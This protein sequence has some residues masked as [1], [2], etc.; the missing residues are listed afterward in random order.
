MDMEF[1]KVAQE[2]AEVEKEIRKQ[3][4]KIDDI[5]ALL[6]KDF[7][8][9]ARREKNLYGDEEQEARNLLRKKEGQLREK[10]GQLREEKKVLREKEQELLKQK[11][12]LLNGQGATSQLVADSQIGSPSSLKRVIKQALDEHEHSNTSSKR[13]ARD[14]D[15]F[16]ARIKVRDGKCVISGS[17]EYEACHLVPFKFWKDNRGLWDQLFRSECHK[18]DD[19]VNDVRNGVLLSKKWHTHFDSLRITIVRVKEK[20]KVKSCS[21]YTFPA[22]DMCFLAKTL[23]FGK[24]K[25][26]WPGEAFLLYHNREFEKKD[27]I[28][29]LLSG[30]MKA[31]AESDTSDRDDA[32]TSQRDQQIMLTDDDF[33]SEMQQSWLDRQAH[34]YAAAD[35][36]LVA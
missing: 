22:E 33:K 12:I 1:V 24:P 10:E 21:W 36:S 5:E 32:D 2:L 35:Y 4:S 20:F 9:W 18:A 27:A 19:E 17:K 28:S 23:S 34:L 29:A 3:T 13:S 26:R 14:Q 6:S 15:A 11:T 31:K 30:K 16:R 8:E 25:T 7:T